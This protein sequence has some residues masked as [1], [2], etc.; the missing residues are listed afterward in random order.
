MKLHS[1][2][3]TWSLSGIQATKRKLSMVDET[4][5]TKNTTSSIKVLNYR[6]I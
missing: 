1:I 3:Q 5:K 4:M 2:F 6:N